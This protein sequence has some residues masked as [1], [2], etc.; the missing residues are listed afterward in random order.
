MQVPFPQRCDAHGRREGEQQPHR[1]PE[2]NSSP[3][4]HLH[5]Q[6]GAGHGSPSVQ[7]L[8]AALHVEKRRRRERREGAGGEMT[9]PVLGA[10]ARGR[11]CRWHAGAGSRRV[12]WAASCLLQHGDAGV[13]DFGVHFARGG[14]IFSQQ[15]GSRQHSRAGVARV[16]RRRRG[17]APARARTLALLER[18][19]AEGMQQPQAARHGQWFTATAASARLTRGRQA[20]EALLNEVGAPGVDDALRE[21]EGRGKAGR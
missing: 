9:R 2:R 4:G 20:G 8:G 1:N 18:R 15:R 19:A 7:L 17:A 10:A 21:A 11:R 5:V 12:C 13:G 16:R 6:H 14:C 3:D